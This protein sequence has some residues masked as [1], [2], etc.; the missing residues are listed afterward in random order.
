VEKR[1][2]GD[3][4]NV[5]VLGCSAG[6]E[7]YSVAWRI[8]SAR[9]DLRLTLQA[10]DLSEQAIEVARCGVYSPEVSK[11]TRT[12]IFDHMTKS[13][14]VE[15]FDEKEDVLT[16][17][18]WIREGIKWRVG[19][20]RDPEVH[21]ALGLQDI[22]IAN[23]FLC[24]MNAA[25]ADK[26]LRDISRLVKKDGYLF[27]SGIDLD[28]KVR[29]ATDLGWMPIE[30]LLEEIHHGDPRM[31]VEWPWSY[32][33]LEPFNKKKQGWRLRYAQ[34]FQVT[35]SRRIRENLVRGSEGPRTFG[36]AASIP[37]SCRRSFFHRS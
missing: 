26:C 4:L 27:V 3:I 13:E 32:S 8:R 17:K 15:L 16:I 7:A 20:V 23:N 14:I 10:V 19:D 31:M 2:D 21:N 33:S 34:S 24:H 1:T 30:E 29:V 5:A 35:S 9:P 37:A 18:S 28:V 25:E 6:A 36:S 22:V 12:D 11:V